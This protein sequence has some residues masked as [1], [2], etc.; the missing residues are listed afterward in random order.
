MTCLRSQK[1]DVEEQGLSLSTERVRR[2]TLGVSVMVMRGRGT[3]VGETS[4]ASSV[5]TEPEKAK[6]VCSP[7]IAWRA[8][9]AVQGAGR[10]GPGR[11]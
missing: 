11:I 7:H 2:T 4:P 1:E 6:V 10:Q 3:F 9:R 5:G 8:L